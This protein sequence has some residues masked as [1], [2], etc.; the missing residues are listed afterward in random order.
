MRGGGNIIG[1]VLAALSL[2]PIRVVRTSGDDRRR[3]AKRG[4]SPLSV[5]HDSVT[6]GRMQGDRPGWRA[7]AC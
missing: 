3:V 1:S 7:I 2:P 4:E 6:G 5:A